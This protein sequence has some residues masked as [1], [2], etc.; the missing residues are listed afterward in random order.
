MWIYGRSGLL[1]MR[2]PMLIIYVVSFYSMIHYADVL[3]PIA[4]AISP[5]V[6]Q[7]VVKV[8]MSKEIV[9]F[10][11][12]FLA[13]A[14]LFLFDR[15]LMLLAIPSIFFWQYGQFLILPCLVIL[16]ASGRP[17]LKTDLSY[18]MYLSGGPIQQSILHFLPEVALLPMFG[19]SIIITM[20]TAWAIRLRPSIDKF[21]HL[22]QLR[23]S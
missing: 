15:R 17:L 1:K 3:T 21:S 8:M 13:G 19:L 23:R 22:L 6:P 12:D 18:E 20:L 9:E 4:G 2:Y 7:D 16:A 11:L 14:L 5:F 10:N